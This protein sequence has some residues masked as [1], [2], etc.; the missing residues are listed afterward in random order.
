MPRI[1][2]FI[3]SC[4]IFNYIFTKSVLHIHFNTYYLIKVIGNLLEALLSMLLNI[5]DLKA[6]TMHVKN[7]NKEMF[8]F[9]YRFQRFYFIFVFIFL[10]LF[11]NW[12]KENK[13]ITE[14]EL[15]L[16]WPF[17]FWIQRVAISFLFWTQRVAI[18]TFSNIFTND[19]KFWHILERGGEEEGKKEAKEL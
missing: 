4:C 12:K 7:K 18:S 8:F 9:T 2:C 5:N 19:K 15:K 14:I 13:W 17:L 10:F 11:Y 1:F 16:R 3:H 6:N